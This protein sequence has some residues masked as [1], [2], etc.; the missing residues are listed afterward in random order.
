MAW[1]WSLG[2]VFPPPKKKRSPSI[3]EKYRFLRDYP[4]ISVFSTLYRP[5]AALSEGHRR[6]KESGGRFL[7][8][9]CEAAIPC[10]LISHVVASCCSK[11]KFALGNFKATESYMAKL[12]ESSR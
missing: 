4:F 11:R 12:E 9:L 2:F 10:P 3:I 8:Y 7:S 1:D 5:T 6:W